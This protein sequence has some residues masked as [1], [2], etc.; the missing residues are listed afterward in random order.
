MP[1]TVILSKLCEF[2]NRTR[3]GSTRLESSGAHNTEKLASTSLQGYAV[4]QGVIISMRLRNRTAKPL[5]TFSF[6]RFVQLSTFFL[7]KLDETLK[8]HT[9]IQTYK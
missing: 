3:S 7:I 6:T 8:K 9:N 1:E 5:P 2:H 4:Y